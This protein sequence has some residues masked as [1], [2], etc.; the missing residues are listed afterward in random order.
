M[1]TPFAD[2]ELAQQGALRGGEQNRRQLAHRKVRHVALGEAQ[3]V[4]GAELRQRHQSRERGD[5]QKGDVGAAGG[6]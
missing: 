3:D 2:Y 5:A 6:Q 1:C 4:G